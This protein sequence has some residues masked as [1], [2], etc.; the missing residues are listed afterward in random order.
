MVSSTQASNSSLPVWS[1]AECSL[2]PLVRTVSTTGASGTLDHVTAVYADQLIR[3]WTRR[4]ESLHFKVDDPIQFSKNLHEAK[5]FPLED[6]TRVQLYPGGRLTK[7]AVLRL[8]GSDRADFLLPHDQ[9]TRV[10]AF[11]ANKLGV[12]SNLKANL[13]FMAA[14][15]LACC[16]SS[17]CLDSPL[18][19]CRRPCYRRAFPVEWGEVG[20]S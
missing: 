14:G 3:G 18:G 15:C 12:D 20:R 8:R 11:L 4:L 2:L 10:A 1:E 16:F 13:F 19:T 6:T 7:R 17:G 5:G 9:T